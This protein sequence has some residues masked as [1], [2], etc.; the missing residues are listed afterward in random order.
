MTLLNRFL[1]FASLIVLTSLATGS[2]TAQEKRSPSLD[3]RDS[4]SSDFVIRKT[5]RRVVVD[6][7]VTDKQGNAVTGLTMKD[8][9]LKEDDKPQQLLSFDVHDGSKPDYVPPKVPP[10]PPNTFVDV[11]KEAEQ[12]PL[13][14]ILYDMVNM[15]QNDQASSRKPLLSFID[16]KPPG[17]RFAIF[18]NTDQT[19]LIQG[20]TSDRE[21]LHAALTSQGP[22]PHLPSQFLYGANYGKQNTGAAVSMFSQL[23]N[24]L[25]GI[26]GRKNLLWLAGYFPLELHATANSV[27]PQEEIK[28]TIANM[29]RSQISIY[30]IDIR[31]VLAYDEAQLTDGGAAGGKGAPGGGATE[32][33]S[34]DP[35]G[36]GGSASDFMNEEDIAQS[37]GA[38]LTTVPTRLRI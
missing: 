28:Q 17:T 8:F 21:L 18:V 14:V 1:L 27:L 6:V 24:Y 35:V 4:N 23:T 34:I 22:G 29:T 2:L 36:L 26:P 13:Y 25:S 16:S 37:T 12:G 11:P 33:N 31:G 3:K 38:T 15:D 32:M 7:V 5:V 19:K 10:L 9:A 20:F 30:P